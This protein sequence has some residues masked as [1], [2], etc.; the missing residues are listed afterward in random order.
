MDERV[1][2]SCPFVFLRTSFVFLRRTAAATAL[3][4]N[5]IIPTVDNISPITDH[6]AV[7]VP[8]AHIQHSILRNCDI[9]P[10]YMWHQTPPPIS[11]L[12][13]FSSRARSYNEYSYCCPM[14]TYNPN[15]SLDPSLYHMYTSIGVNINTFYSN[16]YHYS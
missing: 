4:L 10:K 5:T 11:T 1:H 9:V 14:L 7:G 12:T 3:E 8:V 13:L 16:P 15:P 6:V 2:W